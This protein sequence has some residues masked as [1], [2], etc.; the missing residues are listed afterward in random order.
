MLLPEGYSPSRRRAFGDL[1]MVLFLCSQIFDGA[2]TYVGLSVFG[3]SVEANPVVSWLI[4]AVGPGAALM[5]AKG[6]AIAFGA[7]LHLSS[8]HHVVAAL[9]GIY[10]VLALA[11]WTYLL[12]FLH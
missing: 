2:L 12:F 5:S 4:H 9:T 3:P 11:P 6:A 7:F 10:V 1:V 8:V